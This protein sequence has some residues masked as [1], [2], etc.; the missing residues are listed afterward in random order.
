MQSQQFTNFMV[1]FLSINITSNCSIYYLSE[2]F[3]QDSSRFQVWKPD[4]T[5]YSVCRSNLV[6]HL[7]R[8]YLFISVIP[9]GWH[10]SAE[11]EKD[12]GSAGKTYSGSNF[13]ATQ[14]II[15]Q[16]TALISQIGA[17]SANSLPF[18]SICQDRG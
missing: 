18:L 5:L 6:Y 10:N 2:R 14:Y 17:H 16:R 4:I 3:H 9:E 8:M 1:N 11:M 7:S 12:R 15:W 13:V